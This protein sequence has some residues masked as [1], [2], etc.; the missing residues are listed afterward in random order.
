MRRVLKMFHMKVIKT[1]VFSS[2]CQVFKD[3]AVKGFT[4]FWERQSPTLPTPD[5]DNK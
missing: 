1:T 2:S 4:G 5:P 3:L